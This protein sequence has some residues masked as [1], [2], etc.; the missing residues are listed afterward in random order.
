MVSPAS[1]GAYLNNC[2]QL[3]AD[4][5]ALTLTTTSPLSAMPHMCAYSDT[6]ISAVMNTQVDIAY[7]NDKLVGTASCQSEVYEPV[8][9][10]PF[11]W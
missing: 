9:V 1:Y 6:H 7:R 5:V 10:S 2:Q 8:T 4:D 3:A 11:Y